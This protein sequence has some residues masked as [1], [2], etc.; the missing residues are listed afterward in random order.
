M[1]I[2]QSMR[3]ALRG[4][5]ANLLRTGLT[6]L[7]IIIGVAVVILVVAIGQGATKAV[8]DQISALGT[9]LIT[10]RP[11]PRQIRKNLYGGN[12][13]ERPNGCRRQRYW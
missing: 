3:L 13:G 4:L 5:S 12:T 1:N 9:N 7:G 8:N 11:S 6:M 2:L 10:V